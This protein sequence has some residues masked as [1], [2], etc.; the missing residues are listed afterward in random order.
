MLPN[1]QLRRLDMRDMYKLQ[2]IVK[3][4]IA[5]PANLSWPFDRQAATRFIQD[6]NT[7]GIWLNG[8]ILA[9]AIEIKPDLETAY[10]VSR[11]FQNKGIA[12][13]AVKMM[14]QQYADRQ[15][16]CVVDPRNVASMRVAQK[17]T[18]RMQFIQL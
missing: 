6:Y 12:T 14:M 8:Q 11:Q 17:A 15:L 18:M 5:E 10:F 4:Y 7:W 9:G 2:S 13:Q 3:Q 16:W 1:I